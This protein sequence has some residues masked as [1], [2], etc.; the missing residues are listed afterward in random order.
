MKKN[1]LFTIIGFI[2]GL[3]VAVGAAYLY[4]A[5]DIEYTPS[6]KSWNVNNMQDAIDDIKE[7]YVPKSNY[8]ELINQIANVNF[9]YTGNYQTYKVY[10]DGLYKIELWGAAGGKGWYSSESNSAHGGYGAYTSGTIHLDVGDLLFITVGG[11]GIAKNYKDGILRIDGGY[12]GGGQ[13]NVTRNF[14]YK[15]TSS[16]GCAT[17][18]RFKNNT[19]NSRIMVAAGGGGVHQSNCSTDDQSITNGGAGGTLTGIAG[20]YSHRIG[21]SVITPTGGTQTSGG[22]SVNEWTATSYD[23]SYPGQFG[24]GASGNPA[25]SYGGGGGGYWGGAAGKWKPGG[26]GSSYISGYTGCVAIESETNSNPKSG[27]ING[28]TNNECSIHYSN[29]TFSDTVMIAGNTT[30]TDPKGSSTKGNTGN[31]YAR[32]TLVSLD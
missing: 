16:G 11:A 3:S 20:D 22:Q 30:M 19:L 4:N 29:K 32:I 23:N 1:I 8:L 12:N 15:Q 31:G 26:G 28:T 10:N 9:S 6:D 21:Y 18:I 13:G 17:D 24:L 2:L 14:C 7:N 25:G 5:K 27:C